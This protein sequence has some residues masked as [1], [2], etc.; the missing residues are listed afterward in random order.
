MLI[1][2]N[3]KFIFIHIFKTAGTSV[4]LRLGSHARFNDALIYGYRP[5]RK[6]L[7]GANILLKRRLIERMT[8]FNPHATASEVR[9]KMPAIFDSYFKFAFV[10][11]PWDW[12]V[13]LYYFFRQN[14]RD[15]RHDKAMA[16]SFPDFVEWQ[17]EEQIQRQLDFITDTAG[18][19]IVD[20]IGKYETLNQ[21][22]EYVIHKL[23]IDAPSLPRMNV[24]NARKNRDYRRFYTDAAYE[25]VLNYFQDDIKTFNYSFD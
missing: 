16:I 14:K 21:D 3:H 18:N 24:S 2:H 22:Y 20:F 19:I 4:S 13:S 1:S 5:S 12:L 10:R 17:I 8:G 15:P 9:E 7:L 6:V 11:N 23:S 25:M